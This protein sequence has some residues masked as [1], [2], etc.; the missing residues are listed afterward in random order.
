MG[1][2]VIVKSIY[3]YPQRDCTTVN[4]PTVVARG[5][6]E[7]VVLLQLCELGGEGRRDR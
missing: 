7:N 2:K 6:S 3:G 1:Q 5:V 4:I